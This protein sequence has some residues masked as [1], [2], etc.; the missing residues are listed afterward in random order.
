[1]GKGPICIT[2]AEKQKSR[3]EEKQRNREKQK[4][5]AEKQKS[6]QNRKNES[7]KIKIKDRQDRNTFFEFKQYHTAYGCPKLTAPQDVG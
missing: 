1:M 6:F 4:G 5:R 2:K 7:G 3:K